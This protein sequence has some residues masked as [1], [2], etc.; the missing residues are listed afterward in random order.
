MTE[1]M[2]HAFQIFDGYW[3]EN[4]ST[5]VLGM[6]MELDSEVRDEIFRILL[7]RSG[8][9][10]LVDAKVSIQREVLVKAEDGKHA[11]RLDLLLT[12]PGQSGEPDYALGVEVKLWGYGQSDDELAEQLTRYRGW[13]T[14]EFQ[15]SRLLFLAVKPLAGDVRDACDGWVLWSEL[16]DTLRQAFDRSEGFRGHFLSNALMC[17]EEATTDFT[18]F[19]TLVTYKTT[20]PDPEEDE[21][22]W[23]VY[24]FLGALRPRFGDLA[25]NVVC[26]DYRGLRAD[27][28]WNYS[29]CR[30]SIWPNDDWFH[31]VGFY[32]FLDG[33]RSPNQK[34]GGFFCV[35]KKDEDLVFSLTVEE[36]LQRSTETEWFGNLVEEIVIKLELQTAE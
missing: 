24:Q 27:E 4:F 2:K 7:A 34:P 28:G 13:L 8:W 32:W 9:E 5:A 33:A 21:G 15:E 29:G 31:T 17:I 19:D 3:K 12:W 10:H 35:Y 11:G 25:G 36:L 14:R 1:R 16:R 6:V 22:W 18:E 20:G 30:I 23:D 26:E